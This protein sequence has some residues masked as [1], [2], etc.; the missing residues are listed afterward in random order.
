MASVIIRHPRT[1]HE[2]G[3]EL[4]DFRTRK[5]IKDKDG[6]NTTYEAAGYRI[7]SLADG[8]PYQQPKSEG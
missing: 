7:V 1:Q 2:V 6:N 3:I 4:R 5:L 8:S